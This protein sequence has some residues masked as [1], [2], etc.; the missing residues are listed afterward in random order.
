[1]HTMLEVVDRSYRTGS[2]RDIYGQ[3]YSQQLN[4]RETNYEDG[5]SVK[6]SLLEDYIHTPSI[7]PSI[8]PSQTKLVS[9]HRQY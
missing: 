7:P 6:D 2:P 9:I 1:M 8:H 3:E 4:I 5:T